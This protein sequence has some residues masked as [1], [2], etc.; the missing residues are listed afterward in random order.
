[1]ERKRT[2]VES[3]MSGIIA[4]QSMARRL[5]GEE[6]IHLPLTSMC[7]ALCRYIRTENDNFQPMGANMG[8][9]PPLENEIRNKQERYERMAERGLRELEETLNK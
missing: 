7:G 3:A 8:I 6:K 5:R 4:G 2:G 1:M 9:L